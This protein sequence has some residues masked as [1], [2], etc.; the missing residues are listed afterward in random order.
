MTHE[1]FNHEILDS[2]W[3]DVTWDMKRFNKESPQ[4]VYDTLH[5]FIT[6]PM[7]RIF[8][9]NTDTHVITMYCELGNDKYKNVHMALFINM[10]AEFGVLHEDPNKPLKVNS[11]IAIS[12]GSKDDEEGI[13]DQYNGVFDMHDLDFVINTV[14]HVMTENDTA[15]I[16]KDLG[17]AL[18]RRVH[19][20][21]MLFA[22]RKWYEHVSR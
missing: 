1:P 17:H 13:T 15:N 6:D 11:T 12:K 4:D 14:K 3:K 5:K 7:V 2:Y 10:K 21:P 16:V 22:R 9:Y 19:Q 18:D 8:Y 20:V